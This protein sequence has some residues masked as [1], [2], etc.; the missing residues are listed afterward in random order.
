[1]SNAG[2]IV[3]PHF[4]YQYSLNSAELEEMVV[5][6][7]LCLYNRTLPCSAGFIKERIEKWGIKNV[8]SISTI[9]KILSK[10]DLV[11]W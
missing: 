8:P 5:M 11:N 9:K 3:E 7:R 6:E 2:Y 1:M 4:E 10:K